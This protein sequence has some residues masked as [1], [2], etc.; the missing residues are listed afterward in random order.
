MSSIHIGKLNL[1]ADDERLLLTLED[2]EVMLSPQDVTRLEDFLRKY[3]PHE[4]RIGFR[5]PLLSLPSATRE[6]FQICLLDE[7]ETIPLTPVDISLTG[8]LVELPES[9]DADP[10]LRIRIS[11]DEDSC[12]LMASVVRRQGALCALHFL[13]ALREGELDPPEV[14]LGIF[15]HLEQAWLQSRVD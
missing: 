3:A 2:S 5:V 8:V 13:D 11:F 4:R 7:T 6:Q 15:G 14:L 12:D 1:H 9:M 10:V